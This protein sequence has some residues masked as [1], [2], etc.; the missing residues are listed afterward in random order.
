MTSV[1]AL[2]KIYRLVPGMSATACL[3]WRPNTPREDHPFK[4]DPGECRICWGI[5]SNER[6]PGTAFCEECWGKLSVH[7]SDKV[8]DALLDRDDIPVEYIQAMTDDMDALIAYKAEGRMERL[9]ED[10]EDEDDEY[11]SATSSAG[12]KTP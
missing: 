12:R 7:P 8:R 5:C 11:L 2:S 9:E 1:S 3:A 6:R 4:H 10:D